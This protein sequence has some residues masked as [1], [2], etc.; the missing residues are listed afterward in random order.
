MSIRVNARCV[1][2]MLLLVLASGSVAARAAARELPDPCPRPMPGSPVPEPRD[3][4]SRGGVLKL[5]LAIRSRREADGST[6]YC[7]VLPDG[8]QSP[9]L[10]LHPGDLLILR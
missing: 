2:A 8:T 7:Y 9:T 6:R 1:A 10:R 3:L 5:D 4:R